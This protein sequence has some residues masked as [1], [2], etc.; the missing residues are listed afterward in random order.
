VVE[1]VTLKIL[2]KDYAVA[3]APSQ[4][5]ELLEAARLLDLKMREVRD[6]GKVLGTERVAVMAALNMSH[7]IS[8]L[9]NRE[10]S[11]DRDVG[12]RVHDMKLKLESALDSLRRG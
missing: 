7:E 10:H 3:C 2:D 5:G 8:L 1:Q 12:D 9:K 6:S 4:R 11:A